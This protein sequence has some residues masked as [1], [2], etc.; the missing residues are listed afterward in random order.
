MLGVVPVS[1]LELFDIFYQQVQ[2][3]IG[4]TEKLLSNMLFSL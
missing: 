1:L 3:I 2:S 4:A